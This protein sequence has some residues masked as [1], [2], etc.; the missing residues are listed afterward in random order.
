[1]VDIPRNKFSREG[2]IFLIDSGSPGETEPLVKHFLEQSQHPDFRNKIIQELIPL[3]D[4]CISSL[5]LANTTEFTSSLA[6]LSEF[7][8]R[9]F[10]PMIPKNMRKLWEEG[11]SHGKYSMKLCGSGGGGFMLAFADNHNAAV[12]ELDKR[13]VEYITVYKNA[14]DHKQRSFIFV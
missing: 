9:H 7:Q 4:Y 8:L 2:A 11:L 5:L 3:N 13:S 10:Q 12:A 14:I 1:M 6:K